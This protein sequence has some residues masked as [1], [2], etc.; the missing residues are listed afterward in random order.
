MSSKILASGSAL[1]VLWEHF[2]NIYN[3]NYVPSRGLKCLANNSAK[4]F[5][6][7]GR[8]FGELAALARYLS[9]FVGSLLGSICKIII[10]VS[11][12]LFSPFSFVYGYTEVIKKYVHEHCDP[13]AIYLGSALVLLAA[14]AVAYRFRGKID[15]KYSQMVGTITKI[16]IIDFS[17][18]VGIFIVLLLI[19]IDN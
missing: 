11:H 5:K 12:F 1:L 15:E 4:L 18:Y 7:M 14:L 3:I 6:T 19:H 13:L 8:Y 2:G 17:I 16:P 9:T 10:P